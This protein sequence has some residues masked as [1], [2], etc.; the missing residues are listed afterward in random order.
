MGLMSSLG[1]FHGGFPAAHCI[2]LFRAFVRPMYE[3]AAHLTPNTP[4][5]QRAE[6]NLKKKLKETL[7]GSWAAGH[8]DGLARLSFIE[9]WDFRRQHLANNLED[10][11]VR[12][13]KWDEDADAERELTMMRAWKKRTRIA[14]RISRQELARVWN[15]E[16]AGR[17][18]TIL[19]DPQ[20][21]RPHSCLSLEHSRH[22][23]LYAQW[24][25]NRFPCNSPELRE[26]LGRL[27]EWCLRTLR[28]AVHEAEWSEYTKRRVAR[29]INIILTHTD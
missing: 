18:R 11:L 3:Y 24:F 25:A 7:F 10:R 26:T 15:D 29:P 20:G 9:L 23:N 8:S 16:E 17:T 13:V 2:R 1:F 19:V 22:R 21:R 4:R 12:A 27:G 28:A 6:A 5:I 14:D